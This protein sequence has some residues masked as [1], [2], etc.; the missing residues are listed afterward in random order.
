MELKTFT[1]IEGNLADSKLLW[2][3]AN[4]V[5]GG[6]RDSVSPPPMAEINE[7]GTTRCETDPLKTLKAWRS[8]WEALANPSP[9]EEAKYDNDHRDFVHRRLDHLRTLPEHQARFDKPIT[10]KEV[11][12]AI[13]KLQCGKA[14][15]VDGILNTILKEAAAAV[16]TSKLQAHNPVVDSL[17]LLFNFV[18]KHEVWPKRWGQG[19]IFPLFKEGSRLDPG[20]YR[21][22]ALAKFDWKIVR[23]YHR[24]PPVGLV[25]GDYGSRRRTRGLS[26]TQGHP[27]AHFH[28]A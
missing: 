11:W 13:R 20:N 2:E 9:E 7:K 19:I 14:P 5:M 21:P 23:E 17:V 18:F 8:Y 22:I 16:G 28:A 6:L 26:E 10:R 12:K 25:R 4:R 27:R 1:E 15:G 3:K 24:V